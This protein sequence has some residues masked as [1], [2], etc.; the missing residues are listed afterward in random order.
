MGQEEVLKYLR[1][2]KG[3]VSANEIKDFYEQSQSSI[4]RCLFALY[5]S[6]EINRKRFK[7]GFHWRFVYGLKNERKKG[8]K[9]KNA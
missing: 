4:N 5:K 8:R 2:K 6:K 9:I 1:K 7:D 3:F